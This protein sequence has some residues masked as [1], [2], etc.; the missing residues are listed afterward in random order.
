[1]LTAAPVAPCRS[2]GIAVGGGNVGLGDGEAFGDEVAVGFALWLVVDFGKL[3]ETVG[4]VETLGAGGVLESVG[5]AGTIVGVGL[6]AAE[7]DTTAGLVTG[8]CASVAV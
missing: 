7:D 4:L 3:G 2:T 8:L 1:M 5:L 6:G